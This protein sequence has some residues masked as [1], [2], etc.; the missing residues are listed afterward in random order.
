MSIDLRFIIKRAIDVCTMKN[1][2][3]KTLRQIDEWNKCYGCLSKE[4][5]ARIDKMIIRYE[6]TITNHDVKN[7]S[8]TTYIREY[9]GKTY[10]ITAT[11]NGYLYKNKHYRSLSAI[12]NEITGT[13]CNGKRFFGV[14]K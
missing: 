3:T 13:H 10:T 1:L 4:L 2:R 7:V 8:G 5:E 14:Q 11:Q 9:Q 12:A 6:Q